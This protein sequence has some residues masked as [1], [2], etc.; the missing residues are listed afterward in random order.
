MS[1]F[2]VSREHIEY[3]VSAGVKHGAGYTWNGKYVLVSDWTTRIGQLLWDENVKSVNARYRLQDKAG[4]Y[5]H[6]T[7]AEIDAAQA[8]KLANSLAYQSCEHSGWGMSEAFA[9]LNG[10]KNAAI[11][12]V[13]GYKGAKWTL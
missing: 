3:L 11:E 12:H 4:R 6:R 2:V 7:T 13:A 9:V 8:L 1:A 10:L 5:V